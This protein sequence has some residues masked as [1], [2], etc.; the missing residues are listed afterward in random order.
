VTRV[1]VI[2]PAGGAGSRMGGVLKPLIPLHGTAVLAHSIAPFRA[3]ADVSAIAV[4]VPEQLR[5]NPPAWLIED[6]RVRLVAG[7]PER[8][9]SVRN[10][11]A[12]ITDEV[13]VLL[14]HDA[15]R[16]LVSDDLIERCIAE[17]ARGHSVIAALPVVDTIKEI[18][19]TGYV[20][21]TPDRNRLWAAQ[22]PQAFPAAV[23][24]QAHERAAADGFT[25]TDD[26]TLVAHY[27][28]RILVVPGDADNIKLTTPVDL[29]I[30]EALLAR[31]R[32]HG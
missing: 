1:A 22:T 16:P 17:A 9:D 11:L 32:A 20:V 7:G 29:T 10:A 31:R 27:G 23:L 5:Q 8:T 25:A 2:I 28:T 6:E 18:D 15:A 19:D 12:A 14:V 26:A 4:A 21:G 3:R 24:R 30:A 13:H